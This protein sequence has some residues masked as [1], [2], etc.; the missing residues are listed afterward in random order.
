MENPRPQVAHTLRMPLDDM[1]KLKA[2]AE[3][4]ERTVSFIMRRAIR[5]WLAWQ[6]EQERGES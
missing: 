5:E 4:E 3:R 2:I 1:N 6:E